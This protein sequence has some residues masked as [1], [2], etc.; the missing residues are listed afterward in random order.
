MKRLQILYMVFSILA[1]T[2]CKTLNTGLSVAERKLPEKYTIPAD[3]T[4]AANMNWKRYFA[5]SLLVQ[6]IDTALANNFDLHMAL[7]RIEI[8]RSGV[9]FS[10]GELLPKV[11][12]NIYAASNKYAKYTESNASN[13][14]TEFEGKKIPNPIQDYYLGLTT[15]WEL[16]VWGK[17]R[18]QRKSAV[19]NYLASV[20]GKNFITTNLVADVAASYYELAALENELD[21]VRQTVR[22]QQEELDVVKFRKSV[23]QANELAVQQ[24]LAQLLNTQAMEK[25]TL[26]Q[27]RETEN[28]I[29]F[30]LGRFPQPIRYNKDI[31]Y[32]KIPPQI[33]PGVPSQLLE[34]RPDIREAEFQVQASMFDLKAAKSAFYPTINLTAAV[35]FQAFN[36]RF[37]FRAPTS[38]GY[39]AMGGLVAPLI[40]RNALKQ[41]FNTAKANQLTAIYN[42]QETILNGYLEVVNELS[43]IQ[44]LQK[45]DSLKTQQ[46]DALEKSVEASAELYKNAKASY[47]ELLIA[48]ENSL[49]TKLDLLEVSKQQRIAA[50]NLY[51]ALGGGWK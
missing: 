51:K 14:T 42:Y 44:H 23:G 33:A 5:D 34:N 7:Q 6:L 9:R 18:N 37:L 17:L 16:D 13:S 8:A 32:Q 41:Q 29:N 49:Q 28:K 19:S 21:I 45:I 30:L 26:Q 39:S 40:N 47:L 1:V 4:N 43:S 12:G 24:F 31:L 2:G 25:V 27:I 38:I 10:A 11:D 3:T 15:G 36:P 20:E 50:V 48:Q 22:K 46:S 35:G